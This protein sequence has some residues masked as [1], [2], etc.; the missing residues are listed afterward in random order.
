MKSSN[1]LLDDI[2]CGHLAKQLLFFLIKNHV[3]KKRNQVHGGVFCVCKDFCLKQL[4]ERIV[5]VKSLI[6]DTVLFFAFNELYYSL[7]PRLYSFMTSQCNHMYI[8]C[9]SINRIKKIAMTKFID[10]GLR[11]GWLTTL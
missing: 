10:G 4:S 3:S 8:A 5:Y 6:T 1:C 9:T 7:Y 11:C 2:N